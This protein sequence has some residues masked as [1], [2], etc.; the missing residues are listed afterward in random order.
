MEI[1]IQNWDNCPAIRLNKDILSLLK[2]E[3]GV[4]LNAE[5]KEGALILTPAELTYTLDQLLAT[6]T[7]ESLQIDEEDREWLNES[8]VGRE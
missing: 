5:I 2:V 4:S 1:K 8:P 7:K 3:I 6:S